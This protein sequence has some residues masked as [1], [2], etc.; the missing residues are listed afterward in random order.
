MSEL[1]HAAGG[2]SVLGT[3]KDGSKSTDYCVYCYENGG[4]KMPDITM[5][6]MMEICVPH[7]V[8]NGMSEEYARDLLQKHLPMKRC[9]S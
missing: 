6:Q 5:G 1:R 8:Q 3:E 9:R 2:G 4:F 7:M